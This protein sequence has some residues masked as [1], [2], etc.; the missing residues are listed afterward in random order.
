MGSVNS[1]VVLIKST[2][3]KVKN[4]NVWMGMQLIMVDAQSVDMGFLLEMDIV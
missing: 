2:I 1:Y 3:L 4:V